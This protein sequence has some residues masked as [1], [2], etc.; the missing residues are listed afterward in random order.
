MVISRLL[1][2]TFFGNSFM[3]LGLNEADTFE[4]SSVL[5]YWIETI[6]IYTQNDGVMP[7]IV[8]KKSYKRG[9]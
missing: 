7:E 9:K 6:S 5:I 8:E 1:V 2:V 3:Q 4:S